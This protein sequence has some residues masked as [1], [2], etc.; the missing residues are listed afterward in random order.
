MKP[1]VVRAHGAITRAKYYKAFVG[2]AKL[3]GIPA[4][5]SILSPL[6]PAGALPYVFP[7]LGDY[8]SEARPLTFVLCVLATF[9]AYLSIDCDI[10]RIRRNTQR[11]FILAAIFLLAYVGLNIR[12]V[13]KIAVASLDSPVFVSV[14]YTRTEFAT[15]NFPNSSDW[16]MLQER[17]P[18]EEQVQRLWTIRSVIVARLALLGSYLGVLLLWV[19][20]LSLGVLYDLKRAGQAL[21]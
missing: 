18:E 21:P 20:L 16:E 12:F 1:T 7:P 5:I 9:V 14:G 2:L 13:R 3:P 4:I 6:I 17:G 10:G 19:W 11:A 8:A 15:K